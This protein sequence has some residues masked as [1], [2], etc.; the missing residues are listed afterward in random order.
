MFDAIDFFVETH[1]WKTIHHT[2]TH[3]FSIGK[4][5]HRYIVAGDIKIIPAHKITGFKSDLQTGLL[6]FAHALPLIITNC[7]LLTL[8]SHWTEQESIIS[9]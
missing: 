4:S 7:A 1:I 3:T 2:L 6:S 5:V 9:I 8:V